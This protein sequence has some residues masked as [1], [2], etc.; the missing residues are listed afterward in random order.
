MLFIDSFVPRQ[1]NNAEAPNRNL[2]SAIDNFSKGWKLN[3]KNNFS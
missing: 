1:S 2:L 3:Y